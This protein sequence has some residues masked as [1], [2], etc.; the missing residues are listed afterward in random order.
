M[1][2]M[3]ND[4]CLVILLWYCLSAKDLLQI[5]WPL[6]KYERRPN[7]KTIHSCRQH[8]LVSVVLK[9]YD[10]KYAEAEKGLFIH[11]SF[12]IH[13]G[14]III[15]HVL[16]PSLSCDQ[17]KIRFETKIH[18]YVERDYCCGFVAMSGGLHSFTC[19][20]GLSLLYDI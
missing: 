3:V 18:I 6:I 11:I 20:L 14:W 13:K 1:S 16:V 15:L 9:N 7:L 17:N 2:Y 12:V 10:E 19:K 4:H 5:K 8:F